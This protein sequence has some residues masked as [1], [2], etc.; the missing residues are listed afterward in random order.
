MDVYSSAQCEFLVTYLLGIIEI[1][2]KN[3]NIGVWTHI[4]F[5]FFI[6]SLNTDV[7]MLI[8]SPQM[9]LYRSTQCELL[10]TYL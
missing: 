7:Q 10:V 5:F 2:K 1:R 3:E 6:F 9:D 4:F 8:F